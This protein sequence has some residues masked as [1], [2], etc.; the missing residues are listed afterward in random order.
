[1]LLKQSMYER[2]V[3]KLKTAAGCFFILYSCIVA[4]ASNFHKFM[5]YL[6]FCCI[7]IW[8]H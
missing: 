8:L 3:A 2:V 7:R 1:M 5:F 6:G 4:L